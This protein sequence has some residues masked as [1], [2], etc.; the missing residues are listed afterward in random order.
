MPRIR[1]STAEA[2]FVQGCASDDLRRA[3]LSHSDLPNTLQLELPSVVSP[4]S[5]LLHPDQTLHPIRG[6]VDLRSCPVTGVHPRLLYPRAGIGPIDR[7]KIAHRM[8]EL[9]RM[10]EL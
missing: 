5:L 3:L 1:V 10:D 7:M 6:E 2:R 8:D 4:Q 9:Y